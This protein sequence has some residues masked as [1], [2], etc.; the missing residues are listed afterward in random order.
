MRSRLRPLLIAACLLTLACTMAACKPVYS[1][2]QVEPQGVITFGKYADNGSTF[3]VQLTNVRPGQDC[4]DEISYM[5]DGGSDQRMTYLPDSSFT[6]NQD[7]SATG[8]VTVPTRL[9]GVTLQFRVKKV[10]K[11]TVTRVAWIAV[12]IPAYTAPTPAPAPPTVAHFV[13]RGDR[14]WRRCAGPHDAHAR[15]LFRQL[16]LGRGVQQQRHEGECERRN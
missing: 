6:K 14:P 11:G 16:V 1:D 15:Y 4:V 2:S 10:G 5:W 13:F 8:T 3:T 7:C 12:E 9:G